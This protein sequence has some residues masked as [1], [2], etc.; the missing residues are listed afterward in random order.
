MEQILP[1]IPFSILTLACP[2]GM[3]AVMWL[4]MRNGHQ[5]T[6]MGS[7]PPMSREQ[8]VAMLQQ[9]KDALEKQIRELEQVQ[10]LQRRRDTLEREI[11]APPGKRRCK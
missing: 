8:H 9:Q 10:A 11:A 1:Y 4:M 7:M 3:G 6:L 2:I 5:Q